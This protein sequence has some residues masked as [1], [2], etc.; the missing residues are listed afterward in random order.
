MSLLLLV[1]LVLGLVAFTPIVLTARWLARGQRHRI[2]LAVA[3]TAAM[4]FWLVLPVYVVGAAW[5]PDDA[6]E[7]PVRIG[8]YALVLGGVYAAGLSYDVARSH[9]AGRLTGCLAVAAV[10]L[11]AVTVVSLLSSAASGILAHPYCG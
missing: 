3:A 4:L 2:G 10:A 8:L 9:G 11:T 6:W 7:V 5:C 1:M